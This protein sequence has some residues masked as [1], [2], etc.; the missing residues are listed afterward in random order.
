MSSW[1]VNEIARRLAELDLS[2]ESLL[3]ILKE[4]PTAD[5]AALGTAFNLHYGATFRVNTIRIEGLKEQI[6]G[7]VSEPAVM[8]RTNGLD[9]VHDAISRAEIGLDD[10]T[11][12]SQPRLIDLSKLVSNNDEVDAIPF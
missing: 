6:D 8:L 2:R 3:Q 7:L 4:F 1:I 10:E 12:D 11:C 9:Q 5:L